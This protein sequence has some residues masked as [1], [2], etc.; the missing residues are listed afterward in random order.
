MKKMT[1][2]ILACATLAGCNT[3]DG[4]GKDISGVAIWGQSMIGGGAAY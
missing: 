2:V 4:V 3:I 1:C